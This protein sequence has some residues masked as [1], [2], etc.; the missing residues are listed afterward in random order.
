[1][2]RVVVAARTNRVSA[3]LPVIV[4]DGLNGYSLSG[5]GRRPPCHQ[6]LLGNLHDDKGLVV[7]VHLTAC[8]RAVH[9]NSLR[10]VWW[11]R[12][13]LFGHR[14]RLLPV[15][16]PP[17]RES[18]EAGLVPAAAA[19]RIEAADLSIGKADQVGAAHSTLFDHFR[20]RPGFAFVI[21][22]PHG[23]VPPNRSARPLSLIHI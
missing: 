20:H 17:E 16:Q 8:H 22:E 23:H 10:R 3:R 6:T 7:T 9:C 19:V 21:A 15:G 11:R 4:S 13:L 5:D 12:G 18:G 2:V 14:R 1:M